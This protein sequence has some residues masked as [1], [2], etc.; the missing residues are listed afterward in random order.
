ML[1]CLLKEL[2]QALAHHIFSCPSGRT[3]TSCSMNVQLC[4]LSVDVSAS[5]VKSPKSVCRVLGGKPF[6]SL[7]INTP[8]FLISQCVTQFLYKFMK[9]PK[10]LGSSLD[11]CYNVLINFWSCYRDAWSM[12]QNHQNHQDL[13]W[14]A[15]CGLTIPRARRS[16]SSDAVVVDF[17]TMH[18]RR[19]YMKGGQWEQLK[20]L[21]V[22][23]KRLVS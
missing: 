18:W 9:S 22:N 14:P 17:W 7:K 13:W 6:V 8:L 4:Q 19:S 11:H 2:D 3:P 16:N 15:W 12:S 23:L 21:Y 5:N 1:G 20:I 10:V